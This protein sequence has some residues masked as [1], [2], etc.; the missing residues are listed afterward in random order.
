[1]IEERRE[2][3]SDVQETNANL[4]EHDLERVRGESPRP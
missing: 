1:M 3:S 2:F 4:S